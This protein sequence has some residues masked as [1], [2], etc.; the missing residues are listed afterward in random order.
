MKAYRSLSEKDRALP[1]PKP[2]R[3]N[4]TG[5]APGWKLVVNSVKTGE[6]DHRCT[7]DAT[8]TDSSTV[9]ELKQLVGGCKLHVGGRIV[10]NALISGISDSG[11]QLEG[12]RYFTES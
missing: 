4:V 3:G 5:S 9:V 12:V 10:V 8:E 11:I 7:V 2:F 1:L 6:D